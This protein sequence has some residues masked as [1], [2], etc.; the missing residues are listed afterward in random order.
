MIRHR[1]SVAFLPLL[2]LVACEVRKDDPVAVESGQS[3]Q[4]EVAGTFDLTPI[5]Y[6]FM[7]NPDGY[8]FRNFGGSAD[9]TLFLEVFGEQV[10]LWSIFDRAYFSDTFSR[11]YGSGM[12]YGF[13]LTAG[14]FYRGVFGPHPSH[15]QR[16]AEEPFGIF[17]ETRGAGDLALD[18][19]IER[20]ISKYYFY[21]YSP[22]V[23]KHRIGFFL[24]EYAEEVIAPVEA[25]QAE[26]WEELWILGYLGDW[27][28]HAVNIIGVQR[29]D[30][31]ATFTVYDNNVPFREDTNNPGYRKFHLG[32][33]GYTY[34]TREIESVAIFPVSVQETEQLGKWWGDVDLGELYV[35]LSRPVDPETFVVHTDDLER[36]LG[37]TAGA[38]F[39]EIPD[40]FR[41][42]SLT[43]AL[44]DEWVEPE[45]YYLPPGYYTIDLRNPSSGNIRYTLFAGDALLSLA[46]MGTG[47]TSARVT[48]LPD[49]RAFSFA[50][51]DPLVDLQIRLAQAMDGEEERAVDVSGLSFPADGSVRITPSSSVERF[52]IDF[53]GIAQASCDVTLTEASPAGVESLK[54]SGVHLMEGATL[55]LEPWDWRQLVEMPVFLEA[56]RPDG[57]RFLQAYNATATNFEELLDDMVARGS[58]PNRGIAKSI[59]TQFSL[60]PLRAL[61]NHVES[62]VSEGAIT[63]E[64]GALILAAAEAASVAD[65]GPP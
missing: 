7:P 47:P 29:T 4:N 20:H 15:F 54:L 2:L 32:A 40:A 45:E 46:T 25:A 39:D 22:E 13:T 60:A 41:V 26:G 37:R 6:P 61:S 28:G 34:G 21:Q 12:C 36:R 44:N 53:S 43:G 8:R 63:E 35:W 38:V 55:E 24:P 9:W 64:T 33:D 56:S 16:G 27:G 51:Q 23:R 42:R 50:S 30:D 49:Q 62:L 1:F 19:D 65:S 57:S 59:L 5:S 58:L 48:S 17:Q 10:N 31:G 14:M 52:T 11:K 18:E 3:A